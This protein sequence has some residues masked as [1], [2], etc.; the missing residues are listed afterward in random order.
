MVFELLLVHSRIKELYR[1]KWG[2]LM[3]LNT[4]S[5]SIGEDL[6]VSVIHF[7][8]RVEFCIHFTFVST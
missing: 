5:H 1:R 3:L 6:T 7:H 8:D 4:G 2:G